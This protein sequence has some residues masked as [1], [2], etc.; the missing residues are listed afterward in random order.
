[1]IRKF[2]CLS[3]LPRSGSTFLGALLSQ[4]PEIHVSANSLLITLLYKQIELWET[5]EQSKA[6]SVPNQLQ[7]TLFYT[8]HGYYSHVPKEKKYVFDKSRAWPCNFGVAQHSFRNDAKVLATVRSVP[9]ILASFITLAD[10]NPDN[11]IDKSLTNLGVEINNH[12]RCEWLVNAG[13]TLYESWESLRRGWDNYRENILIVEY[14]NLVNNP[15]TELNIIYMFFDL[16]YFKHDFNNILN[17][18]PENDDVYGIKGMHE[19]RKELKKSPND[20]KLILGDL[21]DL[22]VGSEFWR[23]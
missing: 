1:L 22:Y 13:G 5:E 23:N 7:N 21:Y 17:F 20:A 14:D 11:Y 18:V 3:G 9:D 6:Y 8:A 4:N 12:N 16:P 10:K 19:V 2:N 15:Q